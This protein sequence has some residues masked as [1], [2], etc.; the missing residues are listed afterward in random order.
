MDRMY[1]NNNIFE[2]PCF[3]TETPELTAP[4]NFSMGR[5]FY[6]YAMIFVFF[7]KGL[8]LH[9]VSHI[10][11]WPLPHS[12][13]HIYTYTLQFDHVISSTTRGS[14]RAGLLT[15]S[16][17]KAINVCVSTDQGLAVTKNV[18]LRSQRDEKATRSARI[19]TPTFRS[20]TKNRS[21]LKALDNERSRCGTGAI[22][23]DIPIENIAGGGGWKYIT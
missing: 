4:T 5:V 17:K 3:S 2:T 11:I 21:P 22:M 1:A 14:F 7:D 13:D 12:S 15:T 18:N 6:R 20:G 8:S 10:I 9:E 23:E 16:L 19:V